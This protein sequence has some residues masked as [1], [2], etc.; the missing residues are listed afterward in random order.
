MENGGAEP[1]GTNATELEAVKSLIQVWTSDNSI[2]VSKLAQ[3]VALQVGLL[4]FSRIKTDDIILPAAAAVLSVLG[5]F[6]IG[7]TFA[8]R[9]F[10]KAQIVRL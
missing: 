4:G 3:Y 1:N 10:W 2:S 8:H 5:F 6:S 7:R 9:A